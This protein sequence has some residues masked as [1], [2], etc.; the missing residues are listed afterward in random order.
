MPALIK[1]LK[2]QLK[3]AKICSSIAKTELQYLQY[4]KK[5]DFHKKDY[6]EKWLLECDIVDAQ[7]QVIDT[8][9]KMDIAKHNVE[10]A[11]KINKQD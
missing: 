2:S 3:R 10:I 6:L 4:V 1:H 9:Y 7:K 11:E 5:Y 8:K